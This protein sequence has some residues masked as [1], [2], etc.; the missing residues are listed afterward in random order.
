MKYCCIILTL[1]GLALGVLAIYL[2]K[3]SFVVGEFTNIACAVYSWLSGGLA[4]LLHLINL[5]VVGV[6]IRKD[7]ARA[8]ECDRTIVLCGAVVSLAW[9]IYYYPFIV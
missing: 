9:L 8:S 4:C 3:L 7:F 5:V 6:F 2:Y 1:I